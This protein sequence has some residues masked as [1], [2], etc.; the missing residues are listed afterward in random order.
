MEQKLQ[1]RRIISG[2]LLGRGVGGFVLET[3]HPRSNNEFSGSK[4]GGFKSLK[5]KSII[6]RFVKSM[7]EL[8]VREG[9]HLCVNVRVVDGGDSEA[10]ANFYQK[11]S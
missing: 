6:L 3:P 2:V 1:I 4:Q 7:R 10:I 9:I 5:S 8:G 11:L